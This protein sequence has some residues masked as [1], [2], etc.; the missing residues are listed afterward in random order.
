M[1]QLGRI[2][3]FVKDCFL[4]IYPYRISIF[5]LIALPIL[6]SLDQSQDAFRALVQDVNDSRLIAV[7]EKV[8]F[9]FVSFIWSF[10]V[11]YW[12]RFMSR[13]K[14]PSLAW[15]THKND[16]RIMTVSF[17]SAARKVLPRWLGVLA[18]AEVALAVIYANWDSPARWYVVA[19]SAL[20]VAALL[21]I[22]HF[23]SYKGFSRDL[24]PIAATTQRR[25]DVGK[26]SERFSVLIAP[27]SEH[28]H[29]GAALAVGGTFLLFVLN[30]I[31]LIS[32]RSPFVLVCVFLWFLGGLWFLDIATWL[33]NRTR[34][35]IAINLIVFLSIFVVSVYPSWIVGDF[36]S[37]PTIIILAG[38][39]WVFI[40]TLC[41]VYPSE[42]YGVP[43]TGIVVILAII[44][45][46]CQ[47]VSIMS[48]T[49]KC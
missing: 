8:L 10:E 38:A 6:F 5:L 35:W 17:F 13:L 25:A 14:L 40:G 49:I 18:Q 33:P 3:E 27:A 4:I 20:V 22:I 26:G 9:V 21:A 45:L 19:I 12:A 37:S 47:F 32:D 48:K 24:D 11:F 31:G 46:D 28:A 7:S 39:T 16:G 30:W 42:R 1:L 44:Y 15:P 41:F 34:S 2:W 23:K 29:W 36:L 43:F